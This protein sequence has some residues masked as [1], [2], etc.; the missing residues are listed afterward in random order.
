MREVARWPL[1][2]I[3]NVSVAA[4]A[5]FSLVAIIVGGLAL[6]NIGEARDRVVHHIDP[7]LLQSLRLEAALVDQE[8]GVRGFALGA[9]EELLRSFIAGVESQ[10]DAVGQLERL[11]VDLPV[12]AASLRQ[13]IERAETWRT[14]YADPTISAIE[15]T[16][17]PAASE[18]NQGQA[19]FDT[20][21]ASLNRLQDNL[22][23][24]RL[25]A[26]ASLDSS[27]TT[28]N[29]VCVAIAVGFVLV[30]IM[31]AITLRGAALRPVSRLA[32]EV[33][34]VARGD[35]GHEVEQSGPQEVRELGAD[36]NRM[37]EQILR[38]LAALR[39]AHAELDERTQ[40]LERSNQEL[41]Q[42]A[43]VASHDLQEPLRK[44]AS[45][46]QLLERRYG[47]QLD[48]RADQYIGFAVDGA[49]RM[50]VLI[51]DLLAFSRVGRVVREA[52]TVSCEAILEQATANLA[53][54]IEQTGATITSDDLPEVKA[55]VPLLTAV[56]QNL[57]S[58]ALKFH[59][60]E[61]PR[62]HIGV[63]RSDE[64][65]EF[66]FTDNGIGIEPEYAD[67]IFIIFQRLHNKADY[68]GTGIGLAMCRKI[69]EHH[70]GT[71]WLDQSFESG[72]RFCFTLPAL[73]EPEPESDP[74]ADAERTDL[75]P[76]EEVETR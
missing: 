14:V 22:V 2:R 74:G 40:D 41:E 31:L 44:V 50:Q 68:P 8:T 29:V 49:K 13:V 38:E 19:I 20:V 43:Y 62:V 28:L 35:F 4:V 32:E 11:L 51:N 1:R 61:P 67:R 18:A 63:G 48:E 21:R 5:L 27:S 26:I 58:N 69:I 3:I 12:S 64:F 46:C 16:G 70:G 66:S 30:V 57:I 24:A 54:T 71:I 10:E 55:E 73:P 75:E 53:T 72:S 76:T 15:T 25:D 47:G 6:T 17:R 9:Q 65:W 37:R 36:V 23:R 39:S 56:F 52:V 45:F 42:F 34:T 7:A 59:G 33:R 60:D